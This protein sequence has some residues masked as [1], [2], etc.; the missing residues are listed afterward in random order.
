MAYSL[1]KDLGGVVL[2]V[3]TFGRE[4]L[5]ETMTQLLKYGI[6]ARAF[7]LWAS[8]F[9]LR[10]RLKDRTKNYRPFDLADLINIEIATQRY[11]G[12]ELIDTTTLKVEDVLKVMRSR[13]FERHDHG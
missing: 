2:I 1:V 5:P 4:T 10:Q 8:S 12:E 11:C 9:T 6:A 3:D 13:F 7:S